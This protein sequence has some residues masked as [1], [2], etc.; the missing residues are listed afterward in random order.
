MSDRPSTSRCCLCP[1]AVCILLL[2]TF[3]RSLDVVVVCVLAPAV[4]T[5][6]SLSHTSRKRGDFGGGLEHPAFVL[7]FRRS[8]FISVP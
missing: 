7:A 2:L 8:L 6:T 5:C 1:I 3:R 4:L